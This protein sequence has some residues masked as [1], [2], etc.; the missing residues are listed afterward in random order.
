MWWQCPWVWGRWLSGD[1]GSSAA[2]SCGMGPPPPSSVS[3]AEL[4]PLETVFLPLKWGQ[5]GPASK[6]GRL[7]MGPPGG[8]QQRGFWEW[9]GVASSSFIF[10][11]V[12]R[13]EDLGLPSWVEL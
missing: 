8:H 7:S 5:H 4:E 10:N 2:G 11:F 6:A 13:S 9:E 3:W 12:P 1:Q